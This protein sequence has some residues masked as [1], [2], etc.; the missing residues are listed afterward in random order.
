MYD[1]DFIVR[2]PKPD[3]PAGTQRVDRFKMI[4]VR[5]QFTQAII[6]N[7]LILSIDNRKVFAVTIRLSRR[8]NSLPTLNLQGNFI[9]KG[10]QFIAGY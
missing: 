8:F 2:S 1:P 9:G 10:F 4:A 7:L 6:L 5:K 3:S